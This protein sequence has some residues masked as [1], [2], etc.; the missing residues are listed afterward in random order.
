MAQNL[1]AQ[2]RHIYVHSSEQL[3][4]HLQRV[5][6]RSD[7]FSDFPTNQNGAHIKLFFPDQPHQKPLLPQRNELG[8]V[9][10]PEGKKP[11]TRTYTIR[12][13]LIQE[14]LLAIDFVRHADFGIAADWAI[15]AQAGNI[16]GLAG[17]G[18]P[19]RFNPDVQ[20]WVFIADL[21]ALPMLAASLEQLPTHAQGQI[22]IEIEDEADQI[23]LSYPA[24]MSLNWLVAHANPE[25]QIDASLQ[26]LDWDTQQISVTLAGESAR[27]INLRKLLRTQY[28]LPKTHLYAVPYWK[29]GQSEE[30]YHQERHQV[31]D[32]EA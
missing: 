29:K 21:S 13:F 16:L 6:F 28:Q 26:Q 19:A 10:W 17:P 20:Y 2:P 1:I 15:H 5:Y 32:N 3:S 8:K 27:V 4:A 31:M 18:G 24:G 11:I 30:A 14:Q 12:H 23:E 25:Q 9:I 7:D 22:W